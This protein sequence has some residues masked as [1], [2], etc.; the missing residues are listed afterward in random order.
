MFILW[1]MSQEYQK[2]SKEK[3]HE[4]IGEIDKRDRRN[5]TQQKAFHEFATQTQ[6]S[7][8]KHITDN[9]NALTSFTTAVHEN[10]KVTHALSQHLAEHHV[11]VVNQIHVDSKKI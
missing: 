3:D 9:T 5:E 10:T 7:M 1:K 4:L 2:R 11:P 6:T 8:T